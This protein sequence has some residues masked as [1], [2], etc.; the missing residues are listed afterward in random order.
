MKSAKA[1]APGNISCIF[2]IH[3]DPDPARMGSMGLGFT[4]DKGVVVEVSLADKTEVFFNGEKIEFPAVESVIR[5]IITHE[6]YNIKIDIS[7]ELQLGG[8]FGL[9]GAS[10]LATAY[11]INELLDLK[12]EKL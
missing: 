7:S 12:K 2:Q 11:A 4:L 10:A 9:S 3:E 8:G 5:K 6:A 1:F